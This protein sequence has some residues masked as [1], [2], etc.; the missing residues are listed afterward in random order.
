[1]FLGR[2]DRRSGSTKWA[3]HSASPSHQPKTHQCWANATARQSGLTQCIGKTLC[4]LPSLE[5]VIACSH[6]CFGAGD[7]RLRR[8]A[9]VAFVGEVGAKR[10]TKPSPE[11][12]NLTHQF[13]GRSFLHSQFPKFAGRFIA[14]EGESQTARIRETM[15]RSYIKWELL[16]ARVNQQTK[17]LVFT[18]YAENCGPLYGMAN[19]N[20]SFLPDL[21]IFT[22]T[23]SESS[24]TLLSTVLLDGEN[25]NHPD[26]NCTVIGWRNKIDSPVIRIERN[27]EAWLTIQTAPLD[28]DLDGL[29]N[30]L[31]SN[32]WVSGEIVC[33]PVGS[34][35][36]AIQVK[37]SGRMS[38]H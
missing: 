18:I 24:Q 37:F 32:L 12:L 5:P 14:R 7:D 26:V 13:C 8:K 20:E 3:A 21:A 36:H 30:E 10:A 1:M 22:K 38:V 25:Y 15:R 28:L 31:R 35:E 16:D 6:W 9:A 29:S 27:E 2:Q 4:E 23:Q 11:M 19:P 34:Q 33:M 17:R